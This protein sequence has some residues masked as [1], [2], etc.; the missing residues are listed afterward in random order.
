[1]ARTDQTT[2]KARALKRAEAERD[3]L[4]G[5]I[6]KALAESGPSSPS[7]IARK[8]GAKLSDVN[9]RLK[10]LCDL[11]CAEFVEERVSGG[12]VE[13][14]YRATELHLVETDEWE[15]LPPEVKTLRATEFAE[16]ID[17]VMLAGL[18]AR[19]LGPDKHFH[20]TETRLLMDEQGR[21][22]LLELH[23]QMRLAILAAQDRC[24]EREGE[25]FPMTS[26]QG[27]FVLP[28]GARDSSA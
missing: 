15:D 14:V 17:A 25:T 18:R 13:H 24:A 7:K 9:Y 20:L 28:P 21:D 5:A 4:R 26:I 22:E 23:E 3:A 10:R 1:M 8:L 19:T 11:E 16:G 6:L 12:A 2:R 27:A